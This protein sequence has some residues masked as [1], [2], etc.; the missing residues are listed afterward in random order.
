[1]HALLLAAVIASAE[2]GPGV[3]SIDT[4]DSIVTVQFRKGNRV[5]FHRKERITND[6]DLH[7]LHRNYSIPLECAGGLADVDFASARLRLPSGKSD[8]EDEIFSLEFFEDGIDGRVPVT[9]GFRRGR[10][11]SMYVTRATGPNSTSSSNLCANLPVGPVTCRDTRGL[12]G[13]PPLTLI[14]QMRNLPP[15]PGGPV[16]NEA[17]RNR[18]RIYEE[19]L[20]WG[21]QTVLPLAEALKNPDVQMRRNA[22]LAL[23]VL[24]G[25]WW[26]FECGL[27]TLDISA[28]LPALISALQDTDWYVRL[29]VADTLGNLKDRA[30]AAVPALTAQLSHD[31]EITRGS[32][33]HAL[34]RIGP[35]ARQA[36]PALR[37][38]LKDQD[39]HVRQ[40]AA[41]SIELIA[42]V[43]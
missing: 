12:Q 22:G 31:G 38:A 36:L 42:G 30:S 15:L 9:L 23:D 4:G 7:V 25:R 21:A 37:K 43:Q 34:G 19:L 10:L 16:W 26:P 40:C 35:P 27:A 13:L 33:C 6:L 32:A 2:L 18:L 24:S 29:V 20:D 17:E 11:V 3:E 8:E 14:E 39:E 5:S 41:K 1:M 28:A